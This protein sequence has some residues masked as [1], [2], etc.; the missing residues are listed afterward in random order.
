M[1]NCLKFIAINEIK[2]TINM[3][4]LRSPAT[5]SVML[6]FCLYNIKGA[7]YNSFLLCL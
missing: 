3:C 2:H 1:R 6:L 7:C 4:I 5:V